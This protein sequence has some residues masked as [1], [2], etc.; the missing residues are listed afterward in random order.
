MICI[1]GQLN[2]GSCFIELTTGAGDAAAAGIR[3]RPR[4][5]FSGINDMILRHSRALIF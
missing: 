5:D 4:L 1:E 2:M 3:T